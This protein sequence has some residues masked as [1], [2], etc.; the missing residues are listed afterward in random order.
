MEIP[1]STSPSQNSLEAWLQRNRPMLDIFL[2]AFCV[3]DTHNHVVDFNEAF[4]ELTGESYR[5]IL[6]IADFCQL[7]KMQNCPNEC[8][9]RQAM[10]QNKALRI[11]EVS[12]QSKAFPNLQMILGAVPIHSEMG[13]VL[14][15]LLTI[16]NV[17]AESELQKKYD[18]RKKDSIVDGLTQLFNKSYIESM[19]L[20]SLKNAMRQGESHRLTVVMCD[21]DHFK[22]VNDTHGHPAG[23]LVLKTVSK[24]LKDQARETD[25]VGRFGGEEFLCILDTTDAS[26]ALTVCE[27]FRKK[28]AE[29]KISYEGTPIAVTISLGTATFLPGKSGT[30]TAE[31]ALKET[32]SRADAALYFSKTSGRNRTSQSEKLSTATVEEAAAKAASMR[33]K[34]KAA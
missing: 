20:R 18:E 15:A 22:S 2:D 8:P 11:D 17:T 6:K 4:M 31:D 5:K 16:R 26:G 29:T 23:D 13:E 7:L 3:V 30:Q 9:A 28:V 10:S 24:I 21:I 19:L 33:S 34:K 1:S 27:R 14:G 25:L 32:I 12:G